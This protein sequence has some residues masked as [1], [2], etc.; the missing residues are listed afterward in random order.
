MTNGQKRYIN[1][2]MS[3]KFYISYKTFQEILLDKKL[4]SPSE[5]KEL[6]IELERY[7]LVTG[8]DSFIKERKELLNNIEER[9]NTLAKDLIKK[10]NEV[11]E[12]LNS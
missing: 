10:D 7:D 4:I 5:L 9:A 2:L 11:L 1:S 6:F 12:I 3:D 8:L